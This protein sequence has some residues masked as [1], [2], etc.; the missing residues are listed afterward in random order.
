M[1]MQ[2]SFFV[3]DQPE[4]CYFEK[5]EASFFEIEKVIET[6]YPNERF[7]AVL[8]DALLQILRTVLDSLERIGEVEEYLQF[9]D[10]KIENSYDSAF[11]SK[12]FLL[13]KNP[14]VEALMEHVLLEVAEPLAE[15][16]FESMIDYLETAMDDEVFVDFRLNGEELLLEVQSQG[17]KISQTEPLKQLLIDYDESFQRVATEFLESFI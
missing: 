7:D 9:L 14:E 3:K 5:I 10:F 17:Q 4:G 2:V 8:D 6:Y 15:G 11:V 16:Y 1:S 12:H 13:Y